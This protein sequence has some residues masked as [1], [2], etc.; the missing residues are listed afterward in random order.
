MDEAEDDEWLR[1]WMS[2]EHPPMPPICGEQV[3][4]A[5]ASF[6]DRTSATCG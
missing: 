6:A 2:R 4:A 5:S 3:R 1:R